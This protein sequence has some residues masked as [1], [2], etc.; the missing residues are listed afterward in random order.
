MVVER[1]RILRADR[2]A[3]S[4]GISEGMRTTAALAI[5]P[6]LRLL[7]RD[8]AAETEA[9]LGLAGWCMQ[10]TPKVAL[11]FA[12]ALLLEISG[13]LKLFGGLER[14]LES[15]K[16]GLEAMGFSAVLSVA[17]TAQAAL[18][19]ARA[20]R[21][22]VV[23]EYELRRVLDDLPLQALRLGDVSCELLDR[24]E[25]RTLGE[26]LA[27]PRDGMARRFGQPLLDA[28]DRA[29]GRQAD[30]RSFFVPPPRFS[31]VLELPAE[32]IQA[33]ALLFAAR[34]LL[35]QLEGYLAARAGGIQAFTLRL[36][37][38]E[39]NATELP[40][41]LVTPSRN[42]EHFVQLLRERLGVTTLPAP[43]RSIALETDSILPFAGTALGLLADDRNTAGEW[44][45]LIERLR[46][47]F[48]AAS[49][50]GLGLVPD[51]R[52]EQASRL[53][54]LNDRQLP[55]CLGLSESTGE[56][57][58]WLLETPR[59]IDEIGNVPH[60]DGPLALLSG[61]ERIESGWWDG[62]DVKRDYFVARNGSDA[63]LWIYRE[64]DSGWYLHGI[65]A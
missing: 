23:G 24:L 31:A 15:L 53:T 2:K 46:S 27:L 51:H 17:P 64:R 9:L 4:R 61:P 8:A 54:A 56:R 55:L 5:A 60:Y 26:L 19:L 39:G 6:R 65:F 59:P 33:E 32:A 28:L 14:I 21:H 25:I 45:R 62:A 52:P 7:P 12:E 44:K 47:H 38:R 1:G 37:H 18:W 34:R 57:P 43:V 16:Q 49:V 22:V 42:S 30:P 63:L 35:V 50:T 10:F 20:G 3:G 13:S 48:D 36:F 11:Q 41:G 58:F 40:T 29:L